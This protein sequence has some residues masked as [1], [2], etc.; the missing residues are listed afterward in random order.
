MAGMVE[1]VLDLD[2][3]VIGEP[4]KFP[5]QRLHQPH[6]MADAV[7]EIRIAE[8]DVAGPRGNLPAHVLH[9]RVQLHD[10]EPSAVDRDH[11]AVPAHVLAAPARLRVPGRAAPAVPRFQMGVAFER[12][13]AGAV[14]NAE[15]LLGKGDQGLALGLPG[16]RAVRREPF[17]QAHQA[18]F[19]L[20]AEDGPATEPAQEILVQRRVQAVEAHVRR[21]I[22]AFKPGHEGAR[23]P[24]GGVHGQVDGD[25]AGVAHRLFV[26][27]VD[28]QIVA[29]DRRPGLAQP[30]RRRR[31]PERLMAKI[32]GGQKDDVHC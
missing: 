14:G 24:G 20:A 28:G 8:G 21:G 15:P 18:A 19:E 10:A 26:Q 3:D 22:E 1:Q 12:R 2:R 23:Q 31:Q 4:G 32:I 13:Q 27:V 6:G 5:V 30:R 7:E 25:Q 11:R 17:I 29:G 16:R 9:H